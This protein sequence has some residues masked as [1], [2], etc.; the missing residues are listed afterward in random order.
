MPFESE[1]SPH[2][3]FPSSIKFLKCP[4]NQN[5]LATTRK[6]VESTKLISYR[7]PAISSW[8][9]WSEEVVFLSLILRNHYRILENRCFI[10]FVIMSEA[11][12]TVRME[13]NKK[14]YNLSITHT[15]GVVAMILFT[16]FNHIFFCCNAKSLQKSSVIW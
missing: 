13:Q 6:C 14:N 11:A 7:F 8:W 12:E 16:G 9:R 2:G 15:V 3:T 10:L 5:P 1:K 4:M